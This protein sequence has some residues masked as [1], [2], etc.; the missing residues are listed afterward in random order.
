MTCTTHVFLKFSTEVNDFLENTCLLRKRKQ[1]KVVR[2]VHVIPSEK[3]ESQRWEISMDKSSQGFQT[4]V[5]VY[6][7]RHVQIAFFGS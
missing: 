5:N 4:M 7:V 1:R 3:E 2:K 6:S